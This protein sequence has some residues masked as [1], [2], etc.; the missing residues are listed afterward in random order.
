MNALLASLLGLGMLVSPQSDEIAAPRADVDLVKAPPRHDAWTGMRVGDVL[1]EDDVERVILLKVV[2]S[3]TADL[4]L[5]NL[6]RLLREAAD[7]RFSDGEPA[8]PWR[9]PDADATWEA[10]LITSDGRVFALAVR[11]ERACLR[12]QDGGAGCF[13]PP[14][15]M[16]RCV[17]RPA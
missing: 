5:A 12:D 8:W 15:R 6:R 2:T 4:D 1:S 3:A 17:S 7:A 9:G 10:V 14:P 16:P 11:A 13:A